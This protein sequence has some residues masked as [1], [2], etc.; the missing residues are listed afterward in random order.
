[1]CKAYPHR[2]AELEQYGADIKEIGILIEIE[3]CFSQKK[4]HLRN[5]CMK[6]DKTSF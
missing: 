4:H 1:M 3:H 5:T 6:I 2:K